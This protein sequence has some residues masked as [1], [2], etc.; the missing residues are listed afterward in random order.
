[1]ETDTNNTN[2]LINL[3]QEIPIHSPGSFT[4][5]ARKPNIEQFTV[6][7]SLTFQMLLKSLISKNVAY[8]KLFKLIYEQALNKDF[9]QNSISNCIHSGFLFAISVSRI[10]TCFVVAAQP[11]AFRIQLSYQLVIIIGTFRLQLA[12]MN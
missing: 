12:M 1:V 6:K 9:T 7:L 3:H 5:M 4:V 10:Q 11:F 2:L 8:V